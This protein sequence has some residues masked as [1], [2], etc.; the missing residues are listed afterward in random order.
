MPPSY[1][2]EMFSSNTI[3]NAV[4]E[5]N[6]VPWFLK[7]TLHS[8]ALHVAHI[9]NTLQNG[10]LGDE[11]LSKYIISVYILYLSIFP[12]YLFMR[13]I[14]ICL[15][16]ADIVFST[17]NIFK[18]TFYFWTCCF[19]WVGLCMSVFN[20]ILTSLNGQTWTNSWFQYNFATTV[21]SYISINI[22]GPSSR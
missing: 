19:L 22:H 20:T 2:T 15:T 8:R 11:N 14:L 3:F 13:L 18:T 12:C 10:A 17:P 5:K 16:E 21:Y 1:T 9:M 4:F 7:C 6:V